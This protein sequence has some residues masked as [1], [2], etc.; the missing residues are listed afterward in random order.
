MNG[1]LALII[2]VKF[3]VIF[4]LN[5]NTK[6]HFVFFFSFAGKPCSHE[7]SR[8]KHL[9]GGYIPRCDEE[10]FYKPLQCHGSIGQCW[11]VDK[12]GVEFLNSRNKGKIECAKFDGD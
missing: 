2:K 11:C 4:N 9:I 7:Y 8:R 12:Y 10:G 5:L 6:L 3:N 1:A